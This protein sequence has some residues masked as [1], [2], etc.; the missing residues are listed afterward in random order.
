MS[1]EV[2][3][4][5]S[6]KVSEF[7]TVCRL[8]IRIKLREAAVKEQFQWVFSYVQR[9]LVDVWKENTLE[10][11]E[12]GLLEYKIVGEFLADIKKE[13]GRGDEKLGKV[14]ELKRLEQRGKTMEEFVQEFRRVARGSGYE[15]RLLV[16]EFKR[17]IN[18]TI[19]QR[20]IEL[21][22]QPG[23][24]EQWYDRAISLDRNW[25]KSR[26]EEERLRG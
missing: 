17:G 9:R 23:S 10:D 1:A 12:E 25:R 18:A 19:C 16:E 3:N 14:A 15:R 24:I 22:W 13:F 8:Y 21:E 20:L 2:F 26:K 4:G 7:I 6:S 11:L 5:T